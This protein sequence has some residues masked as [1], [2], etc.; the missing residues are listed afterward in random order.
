MKSYKVDPEK[1]SLKKKKRK[2]NRKQIEK[3]TKIQIFEFLLKNI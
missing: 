1:K 2:K 3:L